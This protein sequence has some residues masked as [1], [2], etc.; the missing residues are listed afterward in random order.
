MSTLSPAAAWALR[1]ALAAAAALAAL[2]CARLLG[3]SAAA[4]GL[5]RPRRGGA[6]PLLC[7]CAVAAVSTL[8]DPGASGALPEGRTARLLAG[9]YLCAA[10][11]LAEELIFR[12][13]VQSALSPALGAWSAAVQAVLFALAH[14]GAA[15]MAY[16]LAF[17]LALGWLARRTKSI[18]PGAAVHAANNA[19]VFAILWSKGAAG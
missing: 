17:G 19:L 12:G 10:A 6:L 18:W 8:W 7:C 13:A 2:G 9:L 3:F 16:A 14:T 5:C 11:P 1:L 4:V 15:Q